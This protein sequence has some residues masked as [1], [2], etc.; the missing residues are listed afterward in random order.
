MNQDNFE[1]LTNRLVKELPGRSAHARMS[2]FRKYIDPPEDSGVLSAVCI[3]LNQFDDSLNVTLI[4]RTS[5]NVN[6]RHSGQISFPGGK[7]DPG[8]ATYVDCAL[9]EA[10]EEI[11]LV[12]DEVQLI[13]QLTPLYIS[14]SNFIV[15]P[16]VFGMEKQQ[17]FVPQPSEVDEI[18][19]VSL[20]FLDKNLDTI[21]M[22][23]SGGIK[24]KNVPYFKFNQKVI[25]GATAMILNELIHISKEINLI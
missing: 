12:K 20:D 6:D 19:D 25:W 14:V 3:L 10:N 24:L 11:N 2:T 1:L 15:H 23:V 9:R 16:V 4:Q 8:D 22:T 18:F 13:G 5:S 17:V 7:M 21:D